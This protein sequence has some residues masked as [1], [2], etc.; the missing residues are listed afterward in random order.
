MT[1]AYYALKAL[2]RNR[3][4]RLLMPIYDN[5]ISI[6][7]PYQLP[8]LYRDYNGRPLI[9]LYIKLD[10][11][12]ALFVAY[13][14]FAKKSK[15]CGCD[16]ISNVI[17][18]FAE[19]LA[20]PRVYI[21]RSLRGSAPLPYYGACASYV[22]YSS[23]TIGGE[24]YYRSIVRGATSADVTRERIQGLQHNLRIVLEEYRQRPIKRALDVEV[25]RLTLYVEELKAEIAQLEN[26]GIL[27]PT[28]IRK[29][30][31]DNRGVIRI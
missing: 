15:S 23:I 7:I 2:P 13:S 10:R 4:P 1:K 29:S 12:A 6:Y 5:S 25:A 22:F 18:T 9:I 11:M 19:C 27:V 16:S 20:I 3:V 21:Y 26:G 30:L 14:Q 31:A 24:I 17:I 8:T 28:I